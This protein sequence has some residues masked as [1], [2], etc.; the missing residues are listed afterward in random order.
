MNGVVQLSESDGLWGFFGFVFIFDCG[1]FFQG[2]R[3][4]YAG[5]NSGV[6]QSPV[7]FCDKYT[8][9]V[10]CVLAR[11]PYCAWKPLEAS[12]IDIFKESEI[13]R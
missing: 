7:A 8:T 1:V 9:C 12:C 10:D 13:E 3:Y 2:R 5:S 4:L 6:V 11:D